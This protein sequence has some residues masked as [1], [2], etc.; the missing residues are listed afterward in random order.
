M[1]RILQILVAMAWCALAADQAFEVASVKT[2]TDGT[3]EIWTLKPFRFD[4][5]GP[6]MTIE[7]FRLCDLITYAYDI[8]DYELFGEPHWAEI[9]RYDVSAKGADG[10]SLTRDT[11]RPMMLALLT[12][13]FHLK[14][15][16][17]MKEMP[18]YELVVAKAGPK[19]KQSP[20]GTKKLLILKSKGK[21][22]MMTVTSGDMA[23]LAG[24]FSKRNNVDRPVIDKT[25]LTET[26]D[27]QLE[28][29]DDTTAGADPGVE[30]IFSAFPEQLGLRLL[31]TKAPVQVLIVDHA[32]KPSEN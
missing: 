15:H 23:Q 28:W 7:N 14:V 6:R 11:A 27:Y 24:Q 3:G 16:T 8:K 1:R 9:D 13:R 4:F 22:V 26:Y 20:P 32:E 10:T 2:R 5:S 31:A 19:F 17:E 21:G 30:S 25:G 29:G 12:D 18:V